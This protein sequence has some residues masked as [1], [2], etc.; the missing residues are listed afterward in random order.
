MM[1]HTTD[2]NIFCKM[3]TESL[4]I[5][6]RMYLQAL[7]NPKNADSFPALQMGLDLCKKELEERGIEVKQATT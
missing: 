5:N 6:H 2:T 1:L 3:D 7:Q 4:M